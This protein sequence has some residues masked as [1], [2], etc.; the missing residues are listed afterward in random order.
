MIDNPLFVCGTGRS[1]TT[2]FTRLLGK[3][4]DIWAFRWESAL[5]S[6]MPGLAE[7]VL[8]DFAAAEVERF[9]KVV[10]GR[11]FKRN[12][13]GAYDAGLFEI[14]ELPRLTKQVDR[15]CAAVLKSGPAEAKLQACA[16]LGNA[17]FGPKARAKGASIWC[18]KTPRNLLYADVIALIYPRAKFINV[19]RD[20]RDVLSSMLERKF[21]PV[22]KSP[23]YPQTLGFTGPVEFDQ[24]IGYWTTLLDIGRI[25]AAEIGPGRWLDVRF[26]DLSTDLE[27]TMTRVFEF[28]GVTPGEEVFDAMRKVFKP[29]E[30][31]NERWRRDLS[32]EQAA[33]LLDVCRANLLHFGYGVN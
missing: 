10:L 12:V 26:E 32:D 3:H 18:E 1:G 24:A 5:F 7:L 2:I 15:F 30:A 29:T 22:A 19:V 17:V 6:G 33:R 9:R 8:Q 31:K 25:H 28:V 27:G 11:L 4:P 23:R 14:I 21:W 16:A 20:G 13:R